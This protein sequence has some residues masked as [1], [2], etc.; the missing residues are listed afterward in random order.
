LRTDANFYRPGF[1]AVPAKIMRIL[2]T[3]PATND[4]NELVY[5]DRS[6]SS[7]CV[8][9]DAQ[10]PTYWGQAGDST[11]NP[12]S[13]H[14]VEWYFKVSAGTIKVWHDGMLVRNEN[15]YDFKNTKWYPFYLGSN[16]SSPHDAV[17]YVYFDNIEIYS[18]TGTAAIGSMSDATITNSDS[19]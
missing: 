18:D 6:L 5:D 2:V 14:T 13:W 8:A 9:G 3:T 12:V 11:A 17:N 1:N 19:Q 16:F 4:M 15:G 10:C 7:Q